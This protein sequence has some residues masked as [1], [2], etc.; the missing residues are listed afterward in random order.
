MQQLSDLDAIELF[1]LTTWRADGVHTVGI[2]RRAGD[3]VKYTK[4]PLLSEAIKAAVETIE[5]PA[6][7]AIS[8]P[9]Y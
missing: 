9:P 4:R 8:A 2:Q 1:S 3:Q 7:P 5:E 6:A